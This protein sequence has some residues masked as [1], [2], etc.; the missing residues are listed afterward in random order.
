MKRMK[1]SELH[2]KLVKLVEV[3]GEIDIHNF[4]NKEEEIECL[5]H[6]EKV[7][8]ILNPK[9]DATGNGEE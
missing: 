2:E 7:Y 5:L 6:L 4:H 3:V 8:E 1:E 9:P